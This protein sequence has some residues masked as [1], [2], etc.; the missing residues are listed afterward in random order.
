MLCEIF[1]INGYKLF[2]LFE[3]TINPLSEIDIGILVFYVIYE[4]R[5]YR[6]CDWTRATSFSMPILICVRFG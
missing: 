1:S 6:D 4:R 5:G 2:S 3:T